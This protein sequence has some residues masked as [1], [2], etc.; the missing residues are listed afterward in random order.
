M[1]VLDSELNM[2][3]AGMELDKSNLEILTGEG[4]FMLLLTASND[5]SSTIEGSIVFL[6]NGKAIITINGTACEIDIN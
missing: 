2:A 4:T 6:S 3:I 5:N 1:Q